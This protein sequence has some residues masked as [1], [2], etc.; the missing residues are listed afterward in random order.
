MCV[1]VQGGKADKKKKKKKKGK[2]GSDKSSVAQ[3][4]DVV[5]GPSSSSWALPTLK[6]K[7]VV[8]CQMHG[9]IPESSS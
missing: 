9:I 2:K 6:V 5:G 1:D 7:L 8:S 3:A 4:E